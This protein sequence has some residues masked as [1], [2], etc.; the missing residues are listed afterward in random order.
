MAAPARRRLTNTIT[1]NTTTA[2]HI[3]PDHNMSA[4]P[5]NHAHTTAS[6]AA[7]EVAEKACP[8]RGHGP[9]GGATDATDPGKVD[10]ERDRTGKGE[11][12]DNL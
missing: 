10:A 1:P 8:A 6:T 9:A 12:D 3:K 4:S 7:S 5:R 11:V 2:N